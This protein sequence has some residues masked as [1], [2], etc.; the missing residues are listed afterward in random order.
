MDSVLGLY[1]DR[2]CVF[3]WKQM[4]LNLKEVLIQKKLAF[5]QKQIQNI[6]QDGVK[7]IKSIRLKFNIARIFQTQ[8]D[9]IE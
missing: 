7:N 3:V 1:I 9:H 5:Y 4:V 6:N 8:A 2:T